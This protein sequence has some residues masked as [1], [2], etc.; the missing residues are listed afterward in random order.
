[1]RSCQKKLKQIVYLYSKKNE[2]TRKN[3]YVVLPGRPCVRPS[4][5]RSV[6]FQLVPFYPQRSCHS[7]VPS[8]SKKPTDTLPI[9]V[10]RRTS[11]RAPPPHHPTAP[12]P[13]ATGL[14]TPPPHV[15]PSFLPAH[16][17]P[18]RRAPPLLPLLPSAVT[19][20]S[21]PPPLRILPSRD[22][23]HDVCGRALTCVRSCTIS[24]SPVVVAI[25]YD[26]A[27][28]RT[29]PQSPVVAVISRGRHRLRFPQPSSSLVDAA[30]AV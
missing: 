20:P 9:A 23:P 12:P 6:N 28:A 27:V 25:P 16:A 8:K 22:P 26:S 2:L 13:F 5:P 30:S 1:M 19:L 11:A 7:V 17:T 18:T 15:P 14:P 29:I 10:H 4:P 24:S 3:W 21:P